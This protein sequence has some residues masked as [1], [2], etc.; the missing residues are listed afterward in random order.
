MSPKTCLTYNL[1]Q[2]RQVNYQLFLLYL[3]TFVL[4]CDLI[5]YR[6]YYH[7][8]QKWGFDSQEGFMMGIRLMFSHFI[9]L[10]TL[11]QSPDLQVEWLVIIKVILEEKDN[12][13][14]DLIIKYLK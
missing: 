7:G 12:N 11:F 10:L 13:L 6:L 1:M 2:I 14:N 8:Q 4:I 9:S 3:C 5:L